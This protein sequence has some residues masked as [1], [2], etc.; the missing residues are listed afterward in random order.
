MCVELAKNAVWIPSQDDH[1]YVHNIVGRI[2]NCSY[3]KIVPCC[4]GKG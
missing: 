3:G 1:R 4:T 2:K